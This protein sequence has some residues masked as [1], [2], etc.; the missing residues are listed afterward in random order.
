MNDLEESVDVFANQTA[1]DICSLTST[2]YICGVCIY[3]NFNAEQVRNLLTA[4]K[5]QCSQQAR[6]RHTYNMWSD[7]VLSVNNGSARVN[8]RCE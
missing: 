2:T 7:M 8:E 1:A 5:P 4:T 6:Q 3:E